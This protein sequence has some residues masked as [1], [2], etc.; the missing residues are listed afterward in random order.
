MAR[1]TPTM[2]SFQSSDIR[3]D[4]RMLTM[5]RVAS[6]LIFIAVIFIALGFGQEPE[7]SLSTREELSADAAA[8]PCKEKD[9]FSGVRELFQK[10]GAASSD[11]SIA[12]YKN[13]ENLEVRLSGKSD[14]VIIV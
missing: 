2:T 6:L 13:V 3:F 12:S 14:G 1:S 10:M 11:I 4:A 9:R 5:K 8:A 7:F